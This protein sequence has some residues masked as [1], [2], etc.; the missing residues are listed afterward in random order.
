MLTLGVLE[1][2]IW[3]NSAENTSPRIISEKN[4][5]SFGI[6]V[7]LLSFLFCNESKTIAQQKNRFS[8]SPIVLISL[9]EQVDGS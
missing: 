9:L 1:Q 4:I 7:N 6:F 3:N 5:Q 2:N 8:T